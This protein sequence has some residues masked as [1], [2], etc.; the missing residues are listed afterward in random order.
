M[1]RTLDTS[2]CTEN[3]Q[4]KPGI[5]KRDTY[6]RTLQEITRI[7]PS[8]ATA[9]ARKYPDVC[10]LVAGLRAGGDGALAQ[11]EVNPTFPIPSCEPLYL[12]ALEHHNKKW[13][14]ER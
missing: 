1:T 4:V 12:L 10:R 14:A 6:H 11:L 7:T 2:F 3:G 13:T 5:G 8:I 9:I